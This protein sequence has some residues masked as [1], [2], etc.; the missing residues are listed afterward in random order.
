MIPPALT[1]YPKAT[2]GK[3]SPAL[4]ENTER[5]RCLSADEE[6]RLLDACVGRRA[7][8]R[9]IVMLAIQTVMRRREILTLAWPQV[10]LA[11]GMIRLPET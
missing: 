4:P 2:P 3:L 5:T 6:I 9:P 8:L 11:R 1:H 7:H 10:D